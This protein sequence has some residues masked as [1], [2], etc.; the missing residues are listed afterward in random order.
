MRRVGALV[1]DRL[2]RADGPTELPP[3]ARVLH[4]S[5]QASLRTAD[6][7]GGQRDRRVRDALHDDQRTGTGVTDLPFEG[8]GEIEPGLRAARVERPHGTAGQ[9]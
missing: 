3:R 9:R 5:L 8:G 2:E 6:L 7:L 4:G 1:L